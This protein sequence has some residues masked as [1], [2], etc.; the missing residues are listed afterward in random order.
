MVP[1]WLGSEHKV[2]QLQEAGPVS[3]AQ[4]LAL[5][6]KK[7]VSLQGE[8]WAPGTALLAS[9]LQGKRALLSPRGLINSSS[10]SPSEVSGTFQT[11]VRSPDLDQKL[12]L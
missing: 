10:F 8:V 1:G 7:G 4:G 3:S 9:R 2:S 11:S 12:S 5:I 6:G